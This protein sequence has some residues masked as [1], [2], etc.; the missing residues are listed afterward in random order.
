M[1]NATGA[2][3]RPLPRY[4]RLAA[5]GLA[6]AFL[7]IILRRA[8]GT[9][10]FQTALA[11]LLA[12]AAAP[13]GRLL[14]R[15]LPPGLSALLALAALFGAVIGLLWLLLPQLLSQLSLAAGAVPQLVDFIQQ[16]FDRL[17]ST[18]L[19]T[20]LGITL[21][22]SE[23]LLQ[24]AGAAALNAVPALMQRLAGMGDRLARA[25]L[26][27][28]L[29]FYF[30]RDRESFC[31]QAS[32]LIPL[33]YRRRLL[34]AL[35]E[36][37]REAAA[38]FRGQLLISLSVALLT[39]VGL[40]IVGVPAWLLLGA[41]MGV[42][43]LI[44]YMGPYLGAVPILL[45]SLPQGLYTALWAVAAVI[46]VQQIESVILSPR[47]MSGATGLHPAWV[48][49]LLSGG[50]LAAGLTGMLLALPLFVCLRGAA[51]AIQCAKQEE[52]P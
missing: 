20:R 13:L 17:E 38:Y 46:V 12:W 45:F 39:A 25:F 10:L 29:A 28:V 21:T 41:V 40:M 52:K 22:T 9:L 11:V 31:F 16:V 42:C 1:T 51:R 18:Q 2:P 24:R 50:G 23:E 3:G 34:V 44:P 33:K 14:E 19:F 37:R 7:L 35:R 36:M 8:V 47:L 48:L 27:P 32:L 49:L 43:D 30:L 6:A 5:A 15:R 26:S 4:I